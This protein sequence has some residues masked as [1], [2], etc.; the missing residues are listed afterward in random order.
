MSRREM[1]MASLQAT[2][3]DLIRT[4]RVVDD[5]AARYAPSPEQW[6]IAD[7]VAHLGYIEPLYL[8]RLR[9]IAEQDNPF[10]PYLHPDRGAHDLARPLSELLQAFILRRAETV[11]FLQSLGQSDWARPVTHETMGPGRLRDH[12][13][14]L[15]DHDSDHLGQ[16]IALREALESQNT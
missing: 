10:E 1:L 16:I 13:Q 4:L 5:A 7:V 8:A 15:V 3:P 14:M 12:V 9:R 11:V 2:V 6:T